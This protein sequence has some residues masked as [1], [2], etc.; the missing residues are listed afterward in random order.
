V[1]T[2]VERVRGVAPH[3]GVK[4]RVDGILRD[5]VVFLRWFSSEKMV[6]PLRVYS[7]W[8]LVNLYL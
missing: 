6:A 7:R 8:S 5:G 3:R 1:D 4:K 2:S